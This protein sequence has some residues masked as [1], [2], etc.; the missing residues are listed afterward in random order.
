MFGLQR[1]SVFAS[2]CLLLTL[3]V[4][5]GAPASTPSAESSTAS[6]APAAGG[7]R[8]IA[9]AMGSTAVPANPQR[10]IVLDT[11]ELDS[12]LALGITPIGAVE[13]LPGA[14]YPAY[15]GRK[16]AGIPVVGTIAE[17]NLE[18]I[19]TLKPDLIISSKVRHEQIYPQLAQIAPT[20]F[21]ERVGVAWKNNFKLH[22]EALGKTAEAARIE[23][24]YQARIA[25][26]RQQL[27]QP[28]QI[29][30]SVVRFLEGQVRQYQRGS[31]IGTILDDLGVGRPAQQ[32][33]T[34]ETWTEL[35]R[36]LIPQLEADALFVTSYGPAEKT[37]LSQFRSDPLWQQLQVV[38]NNRVYEVADDHWMLGLGYLAAERVLDDLSRYV[39]QP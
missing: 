13:A 5:C 24:A 4:A 29:S 34:D 6:A 18:A 15:L 38:R 20:V 19:V 17:P 32:Q 11:G 9:H 21:A 31:F 25:Q 3:L 27:E 28:E 23:A 2:G 10:V 1:F 16:T 7:Q 8:T 33:L 30:V 12:V 37:P 26:L 22:A 35:N 14:G 36:E 39:A